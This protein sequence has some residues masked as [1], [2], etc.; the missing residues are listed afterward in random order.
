M[1]NLLTPHA[2]KPSQ[3]Q[4]VKSIWG[5]ES[6]G[7]AIGQAVLSCRRTQVRVPMNDDEVYSKTQSSTQWD[8]FRH[9]C[10]DELL[11]IYTV[12]LN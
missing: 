6:P 11:L 7:L 5:S 9:Y 2:P 1:L 12:V 4:R 3:Q 10:M 8:G